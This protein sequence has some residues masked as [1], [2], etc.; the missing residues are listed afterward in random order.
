MTVQ[1]RATAQVLVDLIRTLGDHLGFIRPSV[2]VGRRSTGAEQVKWSFHNFF[3]T[4]TPTVARHIS[5]IRQRF[6]QPSYRNQIRR[7]PGC[8][9]G[10]YCYSVRPSIQAAP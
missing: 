6:M 1:R 2:V 8:A 3:Q 5:C 7:G 10:L 9:K 4:L